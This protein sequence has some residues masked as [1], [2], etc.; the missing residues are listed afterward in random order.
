MIK[1]NLTQS[2][3]F[4]YILAILFIVTF[5]RFIQLNYQT[6][7]FTPYTSLSI[8]IGLLLVSIETYRNNNYHLEHSLWLIKPLFIILF[9][10]LVI[11]ITGFGIAKLIQDQWDPSSMN[12]FQISAFFL[13]N[14]LSVILGIKIK[15]KS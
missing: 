4:I 7:L 15:L 1:L 3:Y 9:T 14:T 10:T 2:K 13:L 11:L 5:I 8:T 12:A 6:E